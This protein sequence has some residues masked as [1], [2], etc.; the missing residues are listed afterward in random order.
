MNKNEAAS[1]L[2]VD[3]NASEAVINKAFRTRSKKHHPDVGGSMDN[4][5][6]LKLAQDVLLGK[7]KPK[8]DDGQAMSEFISA[9]QSAIGNSKD[10]FK[11][12][13]V[14]KTKLIL[15]KK[16]QSICAQKESIL[17][18]ICISNGILERLIC[19][20]DNDVIRDMIEKHIAAAN[21][22]CDSADANIQELKDAL[23]I[24]KYYKYT[25]DKA[26]NNIQ[27]G[28]AILNSMQFK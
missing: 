21:Q 4:F 26:E 9:F 6:Q 12:D 20:R 19:T 5:N 22:A 25:A 2:E 1:I 24:A 7:D 13:L 8:P 28:W 18:D 11:V 16:L 27:S 23:E 3:P 14:E 17:T 15:S 10:P